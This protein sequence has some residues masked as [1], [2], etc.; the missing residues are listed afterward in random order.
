MKIKT[1][2]PTDGQQWYLATD[3]CQDA[4]EAASL[5]LIDLGRLAEAPGKHVLRRPDGSTFAIG[6]AWLVEKPNHPRIWFEFDD[7]C[8]DDR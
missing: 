6:G 2:F 3:V 4:P 8:E 1:G 5:P 7:G